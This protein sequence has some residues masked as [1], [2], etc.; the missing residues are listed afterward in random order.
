MHVFSSHFHGCMY[1]QRTVI[2]NSKIRF[3]FLLVS[4][5]LHIIAS[6][7]CLHYKCLLPLEY[8]L[9]VWLN[10]ETKDSFA[11]PVA[12]APHLGPKELETVAQ[13][14]QLLPLLLVCLQAQP[15]P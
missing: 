2:S 3:S 9:A 13:G 7:I 12:Q 15:F 10:A 11:F 8:A 5:T 6:E 4:I 1:F 14:L